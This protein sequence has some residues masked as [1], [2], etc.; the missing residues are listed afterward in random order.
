MSEAGSA[1]APGGFWSTIQA[2]LPRL[3]S[4]V[5]GLILLFILVDELQRD[6]IEVQ[7]ISVP[8][9]LIEAGLNADVVALRLK[10]AILHLQDTVGGEPRRR[11]GADVGGTHPDFTVPL[12]G[13]SLRSLANALRGLLG[14][15]ERRVSGEITLDGEVLRLRLRLSGQGVIADVT[16]ANP[17]ALIRA[18]APEV[19]RVVQPILYAWWLSSE[20]PSEAQMRETLTEMALHA[21]SDRQLQRTIQLLLARSL[22]RTGEAEAALAIND[23]QLRESPG[24]APAIYGRGRALR[25]L[26]RLDEA[27]EAFEAAQRILPNTAFPRVGMAQVLRDRGQ[28]QAAY[29][30]LQPVVRDQLVDAQGRVELALA[31]IAL[32]RAREALV[33]ARRAVA[34]DAKNPSAHTALGE[35]L[36]AERQ[37][38]AAL[39]AFDVAIGHGPLWGEAHLGRAAAL[40]ALGRRAEA[41]DALEHSRAVIAATPRLRER[42]AQLSLF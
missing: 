37:P 3:V 31:L 38:E 34:E 18:G 5:G 30:L 2:L 33:H 36:L 9:R 15:P 16:A 42:L 21:G 8:P 41:R 10:D 40:T 29:D 28:N 1:P 7:P 20:A 11:T 32:G 19:W 6:G 26:G 13:L 25:E 17:D 27:M 23:T 22:A 12:T 4:L 39:L 35:A 24:Y 14:I